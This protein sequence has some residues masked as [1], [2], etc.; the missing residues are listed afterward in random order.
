MFLN[1]SYAVTELTSGLPFLLE[2]GGGLH[3]I[4]SLLATVPTIIDL[5]EATALPPFTDRLTLEDVTFAYD[6]KQPTLKHVSL[7]IPRGASV[8]FVGPSGSGKSTVLSLLARFYQPDTGRILLDGHDVTQATRASLCA[9]LGVVLQESFL[10][11]CSIRD[12]LCIGR[13]EASDVEI[14]A[15]AK[16]ADMHD[17]IMALPE[18]YDTMVGEGGGHLSGGQRQRLAIARALLRQ[19]GIL[20]LDEATSALDAGTEASITATLDAL[21]QRHTI[22]Q[23]THRLAAVSTADCIFVMNHGE[24]VEQGRHTELLAQHGV[25]A[26]LWRKQSG[27]TVSEDGMHAAVEGTRLRTIA[28]LEHEVAESFATEHVREGRDIIHEGDPGDRFYIIVR[29]KAE[30]LTTQPDGTPQIIRIMQD[31]DHFGEIAL[32]RDVPRTATVRA[33]TDC[34]LLSLG[35]GQFL[36]LMQRDAH[37]RAQIT[38][39]AEVRAPSE[40]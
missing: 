8:A 3:R 36:R 21:R 26:A 37:V 2:A 19:P 12:N 18:G 17:L 39:L 38:H 5:P 15:A 23:V 11:N 14:I 35:R 31:G 28:V 33:R 24:L 32:L 4:E 22:I 9:Q 16:A 6:G 1:V 10:F 29:G 25:Y 40:V 20:L 34:V 7:E 13:P 27:L 30:A